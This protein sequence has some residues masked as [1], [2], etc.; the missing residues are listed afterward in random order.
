MTPEPHP[1]KLERA[2]E[3]EIA[4]KISYNKGDVVFA[5]EQS[6]YAHYLRMQYEQEKKH[7]TVKS[8]FP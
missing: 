1:T 5:K 7:A 2:E 3:L 4:A 6:D 8:L